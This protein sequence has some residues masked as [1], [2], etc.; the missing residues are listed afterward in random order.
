VPLLPPKKIKQIDAAGREILSRVGV[1][2][3]DDAV[4]KQL[5][6]SGARVASHKQ[7][8]IMED[9]W[10]EARLSDAP[11][12]VSLYARRP[13]HDLTLGKG[14][15]YFGNGGRVFQ[16]FDTATRRVRPSMLKDIARAACLVDRLANLH[17][18]IIPCQ[19]N[20]IAADHYHLNDFFQGFNNTTKHVMGGC[21][22]LEGVV[23]MHALASTI[24]GDETALR[25]RPFV[26]VITNP[27][28][29]LTFDAVALQII[30][31]C[32]GKGLPIT[33]APAPIAGATAPT[34]LAGTL[35]QMHA[36]A[37][38]GVALI[39]LLQPGAPA[40]YGAVPSVMDLRKMNLAI[41]SV[42]TGMMNAVAVQLA[43]RYQLPIYA[44][45]GL[46]D[47]KVPNIQAGAEKMLSNLLLAQ[48]GADFIHL[49]AG[50]LDSGNTICFEQYIIDDEI[51]GMVYR[52]LKGID[53]NARTLALDCIAS[54][55]P[56]GNYVL[57]DHTVDHMLNQHFYPQHGVRMPF[58]V[59][60]REGEPTIVSRARE[61]VQV[62]L[63]DRKAMLGRGCLSRI[64]RKFPQIQ[65]VGEK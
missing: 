47:A 40:L 43:H 58:D 14:R 62:L 2:V 24:A 39:Q 35:A 11:S 33:C 30:E 36:E 44:S 49:A 50:M 45:A 55:G 52:L 42:E 48:A 18:F 7:M 31:F 8:V 34:T 51:L 10:L 29:P 27:I 46:T 16:I 21:D 25:A 41:G 28:S 22:T 1:K 26:S 19:A 38:A 4:L 53:V 20:D 17:F 6:R 9:A 12:H 60:I 5:K 3:L 61:H 13:Q 15:V 32:T 37:L 64:A 57:E 65:A 54:V 23:Q 63:A 59:W 56:G